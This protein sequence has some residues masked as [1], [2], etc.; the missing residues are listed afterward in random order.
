MK[1]ISM[2]WLFIAFFAL[3][4]GGIQT[5]GW[6]TRPLTAQASPSSS[7]DDFA[8]AT[9]RHR[10]CEAKHWRSMFMQH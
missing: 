1:R 9:V 2:W 4:I 5:L 6:W 7:S 10:N 3:T 8:T